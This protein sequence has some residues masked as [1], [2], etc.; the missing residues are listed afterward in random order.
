M[1][2]AADTDGTVAGASNVSTL[3]T[4]MGVKSACWHPAS[5]LL[6]L[7]GYDQKVGRILRRCI[8]VSNTS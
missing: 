6:A 1:N 5:K 4:G 2:E 8:P 7:G 3:G